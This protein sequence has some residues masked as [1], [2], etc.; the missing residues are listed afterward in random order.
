MVVITFLSLVSGISVE[1]E[2]LVDLPIDKLVH[3]TFYA[4]AVTLGAMA[5]KEKHEPFTITSRFLILLAFLASL[6]GTVIEVFQYCF[7]ADRTAEWEDVL[8]NSVGAIFGAFFTL[9]SK[10]KIWTLKTRSK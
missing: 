1:T 10:D 6:Y 4:V 5:W 3:L 2:R 9:W 7:T 8:A